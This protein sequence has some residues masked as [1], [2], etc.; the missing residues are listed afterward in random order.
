M[1]AMESMNGLMIQGGGD[2]EVVVS[3]NDQPCAASLVY[4]CTFVF[5]ARK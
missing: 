2:M 4:A 1:Q 5:S 3:G